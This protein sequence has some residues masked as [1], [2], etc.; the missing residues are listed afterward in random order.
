MANYKSCWKEKHFWLVALLLFLLLA[1]TN[2]GAYHLGFSRGASSGEAG[3]DCDLAAPESLESE[4]NIFIEVLERLQKHYL[5]PLDLS[6]LL[7]GA[8]QGVV[9]A[10]GDPRTGFYDARELENFLIQTEGSFGGIGVRIIEVSG[11]I[12]VFETISHSPA[13]AAGILPGDHI[14]RAGARELSGVGLETAAEIL[15]GEKGSSIA[16]SIKRP[17][18]DDELN[19]TLVRDEVKVDTVFSHW[20]QQGLGYIRISNFDSNTGATFTEQLH[21]LESG[22]LHKGLILDLRDNPGGQVVE[23]VKVAR[24]IVPEGEITR[25]VGRDGE[26]RNIYHSAAPA[27]DYPIVVLVNEDTASAAEI[28]AGALQ[29]R[30]AALLVGVNTYGKATV[31]QLE[32]IEGGHALLLTVAHYLTPAGRDINGV[33]LEPDIVVEI[34]PLL[35]YYRYFFPGLL[36]RGAYGTNVQ[37]LQEML[38]ELGYEPDLGGYFDEATAEALSEFQIAAGLEAS[39]SFDDLTWVQ[40]REAFENIARERDPQLGRAVELMEQPGIWSDQGVKAR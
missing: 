23:A 5:Y 35:R 29:D 12:V 21:K 17:G 30:E 6:T 40:L 32:D 20:E 16:L 28:L 3:G 25:L 31:Q 36:S 15:R 14:V 39:G 26:V 19:L 8:V 11:E 22:G 2:L 10:V 27:K 4:W 33:G 18:R 13:T 34:P 7:R 38:A 24:M 1:G 9:D 37:L